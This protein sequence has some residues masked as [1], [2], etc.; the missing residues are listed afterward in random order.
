MRKEARLAP[1]DIGVMGAVALLLIAGVLLV[2][3]ASYAKT[4]DAKWANYDIWYMVKRQ[5]MF[6]AA[7]LGLM[8]AVSRVRLASLIKWTL[9]LL[10]V[11][12]LLLVAVMVPGVGRRVNGAFRWIPIGPVNLQPS[13]LAKIAVVLYLAGIFSRRKMRIRRL[14]EG[15]IAPALVVAVMC[16]LIV[17]EP[18]LGTTLA[19]VGTCFIMLYAAG[20]MKR[21]LVCILGTGAAAVGGLVLLEPYRL[22]RIWVWL[23]PWKDPYGDGYQVI[24]SLIA[25]GTGGLTGVGLCEGREKLYI[26]A[27]STDFIFATLGEEAGLIGGIVLLAVFLLLVYRGLDVARR[28]KSTYGNLVAVGI[29]SIIGLQAIVNVAVVS[30]SIPATGVPLPFISY[31]GSSLISMMIAAGILLSVSR[32]VNVELEERDLYESSVDGRR[33]GRSRVSRGKRGGGS[34]RHRSGYRASVRR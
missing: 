12:L 31:G 1:P 30:A 20:A 32:Q 8:F 19:I 4:G 22:Q 24:H 6:A 25:L 28:S 11:S 26:P 17:I 10:V 14:G 21:H 3:D 2:F 9:P 15:W 7:G 13:E 29:S 16:G 34:S 5:I 27:A 23:N 33:N 18:D